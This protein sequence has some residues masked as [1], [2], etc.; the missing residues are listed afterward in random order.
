MGFQLVIF[1]FP[2][3]LKYLAPPPP[4]KIEQIQE[5]KFI[6]YV[7][8]QLNAVGSIVV[9]SRFSLA[10]PLPVCPLFLGIFAFLRGENFAVREI[11]LM[12][13]S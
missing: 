4:P 13:S 8:N 12:L 9:F 11:I 7:L 2:T 5:Q 10:L 1:P 6:D 3:L